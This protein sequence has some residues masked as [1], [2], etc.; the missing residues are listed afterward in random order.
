VSLQQAVR[1][2]R[3]GLSSSALKA[4]LKLARQETKTDLQAANQAAEGQREI[5]ERR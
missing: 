5:A 2:L 3:P 1:A 4:D